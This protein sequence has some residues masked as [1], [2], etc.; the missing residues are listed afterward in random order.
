MLHKDEMK[1]TDRQIENKHFFTFWNTN[2]AMHYHNYAEMNTDFFETHPR[3]SRFKQ[4]SNTRLAAEMDL[5]VA[6]SSYTT[7]VTSGYISSYLH[8]LQFDELQI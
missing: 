7:G 5:G 8:S 1:I 2:P 4:D 3:A 6:E